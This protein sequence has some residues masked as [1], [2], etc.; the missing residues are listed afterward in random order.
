MNL[1]NKDKISKNGLLNDN[2][3]IKVV[4]TLNRLRPNKNDDDINNSNNNTNTNTIADSSLL[5]RLSARI[6]KVPSKKEVE[7]NND[8]SEDTDIYES[9]ENEKKTKIS[10]K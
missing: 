7:D 10:E 2:L 3:E 1:K 4:N 9:I 8:F 5:K 6:K